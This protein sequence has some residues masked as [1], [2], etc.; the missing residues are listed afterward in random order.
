MAAANFAQLK[1]DQRE[2]RKAGLLGDSRKFCV[3]LL[4]ENPR[5]EGLSL[6][7]REK[8]NKV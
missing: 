6:V 5:L 1:S 2:K 3:D 4:V 8:S 7:Y